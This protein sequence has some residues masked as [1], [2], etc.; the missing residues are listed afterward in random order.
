MSFT[1][2]HSGACAAILVAQ[3]PLPEGPGRD[4]LTKVCGSCHSPDRA[5]SVRLTREGWE[6]V[7]ADMATRGAKG[8]DEEFASDAARWPVDD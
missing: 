2:L 1:T 5:A 6:N 3:S 4:A 8:S 7:L